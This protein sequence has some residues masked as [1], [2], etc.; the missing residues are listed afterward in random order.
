LRL[1]AQAL[2]DGLLD[3]ET[4]RRYLQ[5]M[6]VNVR[7][8]GMLIDDLFELSHLDAQGPEWTTCAVP[9][10]GLAKETVTMLRADAERQRVLLSTEIAPDLA[11]ARANPDKLG[12]VLLNLLQ[13]AIHNTPPDGS[14]V[15]SAQQLDH[16]LQIE[17]A[18]TG[19]GVP[20]SD[21]AH[22]FEPF[23]RGGEQRART[24][25]GSGLGLAI[26]RAIVEAHGGR[27]WLADGGDG[28]RIRLTVPV[29]E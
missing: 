10:A 3:E 28:A 25:T 23:Y 6:G 1:V 16:A 29:A 19:C 12:R 21:R 9:L 13:N 27:I 14:V 2:E 4:T 20:E 8:L 5:T 22:I 7:A 11:P 17:V 26:S 15:I 18:D 24:V